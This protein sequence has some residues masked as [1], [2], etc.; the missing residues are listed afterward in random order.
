[1]TRLNQMLALRKGVVAANEK[2]FTDAYQVLQKPALLTGISK[3][4]QPKAEDGDHLPGDRQIV[5][6]KVPDVV[7]DVKTAMSNLFDIH[8]T[9]DT[10][11]Q[12]ARAAVVVDGVRITE[13]LP[14]ATLL[15]LEKKLT[16]LVT[17]VS[18][19]PLLDPT[20]EWTADETTD[21]VWRTEPV[22]TERQK[23][24]PQN[25]VKHPGSDKHPAQVEV[26]YED[27]I[28]GYWTTVRFSGAIPH[29]VARDLL[30]RVRKL[31]AAVQQAREAANMA[32]VEDNKPGAALVAYLFG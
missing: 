26:Y 13:D 20:V 4:Y 29:R 27:I 32:E 18:K 10:T 25:H 7:A 12:L 31:Q 5:Q 8:A 24:V 14:V 2:T 15:T 30:A 9:I 1:M 16:D 6:V 17:F 22:K 28:V 21:N 23:K 3:T 11:N 19:L